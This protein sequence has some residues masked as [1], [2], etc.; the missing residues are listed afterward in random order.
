MHRK[1]FFKKKTTR[2]SLKKLIFYFNFHCNK[3]E[4]KKERNDIRQKS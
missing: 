1:Q 2:L 4:K 3:G